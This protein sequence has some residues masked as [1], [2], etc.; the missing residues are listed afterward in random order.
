MFANIQNEQL[1]EWAIGAY[2]KSGVHQYVPFVLWNVLI[3]KFNR[4]F[5]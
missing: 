5:R 4:R 3:N 2:P 1:F